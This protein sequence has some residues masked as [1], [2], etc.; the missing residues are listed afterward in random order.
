M[1]A[2]TIPRALIPTLLRQLAPTNRDIASKNLG[3]SF[4]P[5]MG[6]SGSFIFCE[7]RVC[8]TAMKT[9]LFVLATVLCITACDQKS[10][11][12]AATTNA[13]SSG[14]DPL[15]APGGYLN[16]IAKGQQAAVKTV[17][18]TS[19]DKAIQLFSVE[20]GRNPK[21]LNELVEQRSSS[22]HGQ[23]S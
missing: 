16:A 15:N 17:D 7:Q 21:D 23:N 5:G 12:P 1:K 11:T 6:L 18:T 10:Q 22:R 3:M 4:T 2:A 13:A 9:P 8:F 14:S 19:V 20:N